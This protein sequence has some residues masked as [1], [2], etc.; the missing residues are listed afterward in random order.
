M[1]VLERW[2]ALLAKLR[3]EGYLHQRSPRNTP[4][5]GALEIE[6]LYGRDQHKRLESFAALDSWFH[7]PQRHGAA[8]RIMA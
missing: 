6:G 7:A 5:K 1:E 3:A 4:L 8:H 2:E